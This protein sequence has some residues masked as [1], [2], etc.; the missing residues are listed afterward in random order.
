V[1]PVG[2]DFDIGTSGSLFWGCE[3]GLGSGAHGWRGP[4]GWF[5][6]KIWVG[7]GSGALVFFWG[8][9]ESFLD[10]FWVWVD[11]RQAAVEDCV[12]VSA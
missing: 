12:D 11:E 3:R 6:E 10:S 9:E 5:R 2:F 1:G 4:V 8:F 7:G